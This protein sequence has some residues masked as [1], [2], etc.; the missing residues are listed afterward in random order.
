MRIEM[1]GKPKTCDRELRVGAVRILEETAKPVAQV[2][3]DLG[4]NEGT[5]GDRV[6]RAR[7][8]VEGTRGVSRG[9]V[10]ELM[11]LRAEVPELRMEREVL[12]R[13]VVLWVTEATR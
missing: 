5:L 12:K 8:E 6:N 10:E 11:R 9:D 13:S 1:P 4:V 7:E 2:A 3:C